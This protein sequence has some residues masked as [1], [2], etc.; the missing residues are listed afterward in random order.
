VKLSSCLRLVLVFL[1]TLWPGVIQR[2]VRILLAVISPVVNRASMRR[3]TLGFRM[4]MMLLK[5]HLKGLNQDGK[6]RALQSVSRSI[7]N[8]D[9]RRPHPS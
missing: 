8:V 6:C 3:K 4:P 7:V 1:Q 9:M 5:D 2:A